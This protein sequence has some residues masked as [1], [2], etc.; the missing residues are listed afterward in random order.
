MAGNA[1]SS[2]AGSGNRTRI[3]SLEG[4]CSTTELYPQ[5]TNS[6][7]TSPGRSR[8][9]PAACERWCG[10]VERRGRSA[11]LL[12]ASSGRLDISSAHLAE[13]AG[14]IPSLRCGLLAPIKA[15]VGGDV[16]NAG[17]V[18][19]RGMTTEIASTP[20]RPAGS[21]CKIMFARRRARLPHSRHCFRQCPLGPDPKSAPR[22]PESGLAR[23]C[24]RGS[25][26]CCCS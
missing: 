10:L 19:R 9:K 26:R 1:G 6:Y 20:N 13:Y 23:R 16:Q 22:G 5:H 15:P 21:A 12:A 7:L 8:T 2:G 25:R 4:C 24:R 11:F 3:F 17:T 18:D 14:S